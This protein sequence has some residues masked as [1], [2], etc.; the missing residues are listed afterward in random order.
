MTVV[1]RGSS[2]RASSCLSLGRVCS[3]LRVRVRVGL[4]Y[5]ERLETLQAL[6]LVFWGSGDVS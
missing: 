6:L 4:E 2:G 3:R 5:A 1:Q